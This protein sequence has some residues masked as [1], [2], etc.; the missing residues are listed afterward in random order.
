MSIFKCTKCGKGLNCFSSSE[1]ECGFTI[2]VIDGV[3]QFTN[4][5]PIFIEGNGLKWLG[6]ESVGENYEPSVALGFDNLS[7]D[8]SVG[9]NVGNSMFMGA[10]SRKLKEYLG[11]NC[12]VLDLGAGLGQASIPLAMAGAMTIAVD[13]SQK[14][15]SV[16]Y[17][18][19]KENHADNNMICTRMNAYQLEITDQSIDAVVVND[20]LHQV[21]R[22]EL[23]VEEIVRI[24]KP[25]GIYVR[26]CCKPLDISE[27]CQKKNDEFNTIQD[28]IKKYYFSVLEIDPYTNLQPFSSWE[29]AN[30]CIS[31][32]GS[33]EDSFFLDTDIVSEWETDMQFALH[34]LKTRADG[35]SQLIPDE[36]H[37]NAWNKT[38]QY[39]R[40][41]YGEN[42]MNIKRY[43]KKMGFLEIYKLK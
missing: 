30:T 15:L 28:D 27:E 32:S 9:T 24:L 21:D 6:Y 31:D 29:K 40:N 33:F 39:A 13:I 12:I 18:R 8:I 11:N 36:I 14:M 19:A 37:I 17:K 7:E 3:Y 35:G 1:C 34:K 2:P 4:D 43:D 25:N 23:V 16:N 20:M 26:Y 38:E 42:Y 5:S 22:P 10:C 41:K